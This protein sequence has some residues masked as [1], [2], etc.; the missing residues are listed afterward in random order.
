MRVAVKPLAL[1]SHVGP[2]SPLKHSSLKKTA[3]IEQ[4][5]TPKTVRFAPAAAAADKTD[6]EGDVDT[7]EARKK[8]PKGSSFLLGD[9]NGA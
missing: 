8:R 3:S 5:A 6:D 7:L 4:L 1:S 2:S 9:G